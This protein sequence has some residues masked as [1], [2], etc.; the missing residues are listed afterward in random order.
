MRQEESNIPGKSTHGRKLAV[1]AQHDVG[2]DV[3]GPA[4]DV[5]EREQVERAQRQAG[6]V[7]GHDAGRVDAD[8][9]EAIGRGGLGPADAVERLGRQTWDVS[10]SAS[11]GHRIVRQATELSGH[12]ATRSQEPGAGSRKPEPELG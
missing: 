8:A 1:L 7:G 5:R 6:L 11:Q 9:L 12:Q 2:K 10:V 3:E 4:G